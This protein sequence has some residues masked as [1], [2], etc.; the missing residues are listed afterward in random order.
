MR[1]GATDSYISHLE[2]ELRLP[3]WDFAVALTRVFGFSKPER[4]EFLA[5]IDSARLERARSRSGRRVGGTPP[6]REGPGA[7]A[8]RESLDPDRIAMD[9]KADPELEAAYRDLVTALSQPGYREAVIKTLR[10]LART[11]ISESTAFRIE[12]GASDGA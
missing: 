3:S 10:G 11:A 8:E 2:N 7:S 6:S 1:V 12:P 5:G 4:E 9:L